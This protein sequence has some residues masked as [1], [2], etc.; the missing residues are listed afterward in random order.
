MLAADK[1]RADHSA[2]GV[3]GH[4]A[5]FS[6]WDSIVP[7]QFDVPEDLLVPPSFES[8]DDLFEMN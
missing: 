4:V 2:L 8:V 6:Q 1:D 7:R 5:T 3:P